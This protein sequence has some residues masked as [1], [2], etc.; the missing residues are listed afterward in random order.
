MNRIKLES[1]GKPI[2]ININAVDVVSPAGDNGA[3]LTMSNGE[4]YIVS[5][6]VEEVLRLEQEGKNKLAPESLSREEIEKLKQ[7]LKDSISEINRLNEM[8]LIRNQ[9]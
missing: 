2:F 4:G 1:A 7:D 8:N 9:Q 6:S 3:V 5:Q